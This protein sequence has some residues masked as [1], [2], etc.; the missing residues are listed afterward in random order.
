MNVIKK[1]KLWAVMAVLA[2]VV[3]LCE[4]SALI[5][6]A[7]ATA[8]VKAEAGKIRS[9]ASTASTV[10]GSTKKGN[11]LRILKSV[12]A[13]DGTWY[14]VGL[15]G[16]KTG[17]IRSDLVT[18][19]GEVPSD[20]APVAAAAS[21]AGSSVQPSDMTS[22][23]VVNNSINVRKG[24]S[25]KDALAGTLKKG[26]VVEITGETTGSDGKK[27]YQVKSETVTGFVREDLLEVS[28]AVATGGGEE[29][30]DAPDALGT[31]EVPQLPA[32]EEDYTDISNV[33]ATKRIP[34]GKALED[35]GLGAD[36]IAGWESERY[37]VLYTQTRNGTEQWY[38]YDAQNDAYERIEALAPMSQEDIA[39]EKG[40]N[41]LSLILMIALGAIA[42]ILLVIVIYLALQLRDARM[43]YEDDY[44]DDDDEDDDDYEDGRVNSRAW[45]PKN[46]L[47]RDSYEEDD[48]M[49]DD[50]KE[51]MR[52]YQKPVKRPQ[53]RENAA[54]Q[55]KPAD[56]R[57]RPADASQRQA[58]G[59]QRTA[60]QQRPA[61]QPGTQ[62]Q[63]A[64][65]P[66]KQA[67]GQ[68]KAAA[69]HRNPTEGQRAN[70]P[71]KQTGSP[72]KPGKG[73]ARQNERPGRQAPYKNP[74]YR[75]ASYEDA[76]DEDFEFEFLNMS[77]E[78]SID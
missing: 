25:T 46:F 11:R 27:W 45:K 9:E 53:G 43:G 77:E 41:K 4:D 39:A 42:L 56:G 48:D 58:A 59:T 54:R 51:D 52:A 35:L 60:G 22:G 50:E 71:Q 67:A 10:V 13:P 61:G 5:V 17:Y 76:E 8:V 47:G 64:N 21:A 18:V 30:G 72:Q 37:F 57:P 29:A 24:A 40:N 62:G 68:P 38:L 55:E 2:A 69:G 14:Q 15:E 75:D 65:A 26:A 49:D 70:A 33:I 74:S 28:A 44:D 66:Q 3:F 32:Q 1:W 16:D 73:Q 20:G 7:E 63:R 36:V 12:S 6:C 34:E 19:E 23:T 31:E 78:D